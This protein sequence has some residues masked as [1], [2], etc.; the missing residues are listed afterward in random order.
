MIT[1]A[2]TTLVTEDKVSVALWKVTD[3]IATATSQRRDVF[4]THGTF[5]DRRI[6]LGFAGYLA[7]HGCTCWILEWRGH[8][9]SQKQVAPFDFETVALFDVKAALTYLVEEEGVRRLDCVTHSGGGLA[10]T[11]CLLRNPYLIERIARIALF[12]C[13]ACH[14]AVSSWQHL[15]LRC[16]KTAS[17]LAGNLPGKRLGIGVQDESYFMMRQ[18]F[19]WNLQRRF[20]G[21]DGFDYLAHMPRVAAPVLAVFGG[22]DPL[23]APPQACRSYLAAFRNDAN[24]A[25]HCAVSNGFSQDYDHARV[26]HSSAA[27]SEIWPATRTWLELRPPSFAAAGGSTAG[28]Q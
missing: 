12:A 13:Q 16:L 2:A 14:A 23:I 9:S 17:R 6:C 24:L 25:M 1:Q 3:S 19:D 22:R 10:L 18:W 4:M 8:G 11:M 26:L 15:R 5:S 28:R 27:K 7:A 20:S 21:H